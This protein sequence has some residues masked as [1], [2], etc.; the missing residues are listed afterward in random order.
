MLSSG[1]IIFQRSPSPISNG[2][3]Q[4]E[5]EK[6]E[7]I[8]T[9]TNRVLYK[10]STVFPFDFFPDDLV[11]DENMVHI[12]ERTFFASEQIYSI[13]LRNIELIN[14]ES[15]PYF[16]TMLIYHSRLRT[17]P[18]VIKF[19]RKDDATKA[20]HIIQGLVLATTQGVDFSKLEVKDIIK[21]VEDMGKIKS[22]ENSH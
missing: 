13:P 5:T 3:K 19:L 22:V 14:V 16:A 1:E 9:K 10:T 21:K 17:E 18:T 4:E 7:G 11:I 15:I 20:R 12:V 8:L 2:K 6:F